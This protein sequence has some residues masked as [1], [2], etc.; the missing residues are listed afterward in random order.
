[1][2]TIQV[3][4]TVQITN[5][6]YSELLN[7]NSRLSVLTIVHNTIKDGDLDKIAFSDPLILIPLPPKVSS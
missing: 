2:K 6:E 7:S 3:F 1:M 5:D 4:C